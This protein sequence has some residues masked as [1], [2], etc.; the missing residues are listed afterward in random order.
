MRALPFA[1]LGLLACAT[2]QLPAPAKL[3][4]AAD[5]PAPAQ[6]AP[7][8]LDS[9]AR[10][11]WTTLLQGAPLPFLGGGGPLS[12]TALGD[13]RFD[14][15][16]DDL[17]PDARRKLVDALA[18]QRA[19]LTT[20]AAAELS[21]EEQ[22]TLEMLRRQLS[23]VD[24][25][26]V[27]A[28]PLWV[29]DQLGGPQVQ[30]A[31]TALH[32]PL[33]T[34]QGAADLAAR[35]GQAGRYFDQHVANLRRGMF[36][37][38]TSPR[39]NV[40]RVIASLDDL[41]NQ[42]A[43]K[44]AL[45]PA[46]QRFA[47]LPEA[48]RGPARDRIREAIQEQVLPGMRRYRDFLAGELLPKARQ[49]VGLWALPGGE[50]CYAALVA[51]HTGTKRTA[52]ELHDLG[53][54]T[55]AS[56]EAEM[57]RIARSEGARDAKQYR[58]RLDARA[59]QFKRSAEALL[60]WN[61]AMLAR[62]QAALPRAFRKLPR[63]TIETR[64]IEAYRA[65]SSPPAFYQPPPADGSHPATYYVNTLRPETRALY[66]QEALCL[67][68]TVPGHHLQIAL[69]QELRD[70]PEFRRLAG[71]T[72]FVEGWALYTERMSDQDLHL[73]SGPP[74]RFGMLGY[75]AWRAARLVVD[76]GMHALKWDRERAVQFL[77][78]HTTLAPEEA[79]N[80]ID[81]YAIYPA[82]A[83]AYMV[84][85]LELF[86]LRESASAKLGTSFD[87]RDFHDAVL[88]HGAVPLSS[89]ERIVNDYVHA[90]GRR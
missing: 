79:A 15:K 6:G 27:C 29:V 36:Q 25:V 39:V 77:R 71:A 86:R 33:G 74:A 30:L 84:G 61:R 53:T 43:S 60:E 48:E 45:L 20:L 23:D 32:Y 75:Q 34:V 24:A 38:R 80:E 42:D 4:V 69:A 16:L 18:Q 5:P 8:Q 22:L 67:H 7:A 52:Q 73:Y 19:E 47:D 85:Q 59:D 64:P 56:I 51:Y 76:T 31:Q 70:L 88:A 13:H 46:A 40:E 26:E 90:R 50:A 1:A 78:E 65:A 87:L 2:Q 21:A 35:Y 49:D 37:G 3:S 89:L 41:L 66:N 57:E 10:R 55:L 62:A 11:Y 83:L 58:A 63:R 14:S 72:A 82:Q 81:R 54:Q 68:E 12:A 44:S 17:S 28:A 9:I